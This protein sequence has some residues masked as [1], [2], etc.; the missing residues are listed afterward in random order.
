MPRT[1]EEAER[2][3]YK[4]CPIKHSMKRRAVWHDYSRKGVYMITVHIATDE[5]GRC[6]EGMLLSRIVGN[7]MAD[8]QSEDFPHPVLTELGRLVEYKIGAIPSYKQFEYVVVRKQVIMP[9]HIHLILEVEKDLPYYTARKR[10]Y[11]LGD[12]V[13]GFKQGCTSLFKRWMTGESVDRILSSINEQKAYN[14]TPGGKSD[15]TLWEDKYND[16]V[17]MDDVAIRKSME[18]VEM[19]AFYWKLETDFPKLFEHELHLTVAGADYSAYGCMFLL[20]R[21][22]RMQVMC[23]RLAMKSMLTG[24]ELKRATASWDE[25]RRLEQQAREQH[26]GHFDRDWYRCGY[27]CKTPV[28]YTETECFRKE[29]HT[30]IQSALDE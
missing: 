15:V 22:K 9:T 26:L 29:K 25:I 4:I 11:H 12:L 18:Y 1:K 8:V 5:D 24:E 13:R 14:T 20:K 10:S 6:Y 2:L 17:L 7:P 27:D 21:P 23:H 16:R 28:P 30:I 19:N 3:G